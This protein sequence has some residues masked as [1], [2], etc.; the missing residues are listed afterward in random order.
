MTRIP[1][2][3]IMTVKRGYPMSYLIAQAV[4]VLVYSAVAV[5]IALAYIH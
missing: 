4:T 2:I 1:E 3:K 5:F